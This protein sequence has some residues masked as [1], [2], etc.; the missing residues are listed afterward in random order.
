M[1]RIVTS[2]LLQLIKKPWYLLFI[3]FLPICATL[4][5]GAIVD[6]GQKEIAIPVAIVDEDQ[7]EFSALVI[8]RV[9][10][11]SFLR[12][13]YVSSAEAERLLLTNKVDSVFLIKEGFQEQLLAEKREKTIEVWVAPSTMAVGIL[14][15]MIAGEVLRL[16][17]NIKAAE[18]V[19]ALFKEKK[20]AM[21]DPHFVWSEAFAYTEQQWEPEPLMTIDFHEAS[22]EEIRGTE[23]GQ[24]ERMLEES[25]QEKITEVEANGYYQP[26]LGLWTFFTMLMIFFTADWVIRERPILFSRI[27]TTYLSL[28][29]YVGQ[30]SMVYLLLHTG[31]ALIAFYLLRHLQ[32]GGSSLE[33]L[34]MMVLYVW[35]CV[36]LSYFL[37]SCVGAL[38]HYYL[39][40]FLLTFCL[41]IVG[42]S[43]FPIQELFPS[44][45]DVARWLPQGLVLHNQH[46]ES[47]LQAIAL[48]GL[49][50]VLWGVGIQKM[51]GQT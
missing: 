19:V 47:F 7:S 34:S 22:T 50:I 5:L 51:R 10:E 24:E 31:Q 29:S 9:Q 36:G 28:P 41:G 16:T 33:L 6:K 43:F 42:G 25:I 15:E 48:L 45:A 37:V 38:G 4:L 23:R 49:S 1:G 8:S 39:I 14:R 46:A 44:I 11:R 2:R 13:E 30:S 12:L 21:E 26:Y 32:L 40:V 17:S 3:C 35:V 27:Q 20:I 18:E